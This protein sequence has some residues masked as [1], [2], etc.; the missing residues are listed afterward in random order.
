MTS[1]EEA[2]SSEEAEPPAGPSVVEAVAEVVA[3][4][5]APTACDRS[6]GMV[7]VASVTVEEEGPV[8]ERAA[9]RPCAGLEEPRVEEPVAAPVV[10][11]LRTYN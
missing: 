8:V 1:K 9:A 10:S 5:D 4:P 7:V 11:A 2:A 6:V 3:V